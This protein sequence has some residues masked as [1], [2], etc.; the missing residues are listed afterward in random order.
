MTF[1]EFIGR[2]YERLSLDLCD[3]VSEMY[4]TLLA[5]KLVRMDILNYLF[6]VVLGLTAIGYITSAER[7]SVTNDLR[8][9]CNLYM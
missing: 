1:E 6:G 2:M 9:Q 8:Y 5:S 4:T 3:E 7:E